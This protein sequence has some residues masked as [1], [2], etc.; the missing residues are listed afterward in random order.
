MFLGSTTLQRKKAYI[1]DEKWQKVES[2]G[3]WL[4]FMLLRKCRNK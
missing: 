4:F 2:G 1:I 3:C